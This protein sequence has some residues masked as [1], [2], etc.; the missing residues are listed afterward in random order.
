MRHVFVSKFLDVILSIWSCYFHAVFELYLKFPHYQPNFY[1][2]P[3]IM[4]LFL[5]TLPLSH[6]PCFSLDSRRIKAKVILV[7]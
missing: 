6:L 3:R 4:F 7:K 5:S 1:S 2:L